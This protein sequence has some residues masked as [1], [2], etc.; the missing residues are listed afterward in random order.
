[1]P[2]IMSKVLYLPPAVETG[3]ALIVHVLEQVI[4]LSWIYALA[5][6]DIS[7]EILVPKPGY[8][9][10]TVDN[11]TGITRVAEEG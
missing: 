8:C 10:I 6:W 4:A 2:S 3:I 1:M 11:C 7:P 5:S 9:S